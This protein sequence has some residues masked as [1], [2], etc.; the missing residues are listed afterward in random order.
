M[1]VLEIDGM[2]MVPYI[3]FGGVKWQRSDVDGPGAGRTLDGKL[4]R[5]RVA[6]K[7]R[8]DITCRP[9]RTE[10][11]KLVLSAIMSEWVTVRVT[12]PQVGDVVTYTMYANN[13]PAS[14]QMMQP[15]GTEWWG[16][17]TFPL[18]EQ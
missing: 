14:Y 6:T 11:A 17:I 3:A 12:D 18:I 4:R 15:D 16:G 8:L 13:N 10:E 2:N 5:S 1:F 7:R 9:L